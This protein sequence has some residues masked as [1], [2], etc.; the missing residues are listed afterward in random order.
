MKDPRTKNVIPFATGILSAALILASVVNEDTGG[1][2]LAMQTS[3]QAA[4]DKDE[5]V[6]MPVAEFSVSPPD[7]LAE[8]AR[9]IAR[10]KRY[11]N[12]QTE[13]FDEWSP[14]AT[15]WSSISEWYL[16]V[17]A[18]PTA[19]SD[20]VVLGKVIDAKGYL[21]SDKTGAYSEFTVLIDKVF[22]FSDSSLVPGVSI[23]AEREG[24]SVRLPNGR[25]IRYEIAYQGM[26]QVGRQ[27]V[28]FLKYE[29]QGD[30][31]QILTGY[32]VR[33]GFVFPLDDGGHFA[34]YKNSNNET[35]FDGLRE[36][37]VHPPRAPRGKEF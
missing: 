35:F 31:Y 34:I 8:Q 20:A 12:R 14:T 3:K 4:Q 21:S 17:A 5:K 23:I 10:S 37:L 30:D 15:G 7:D 16:Y 25:V 33:K 11:D 26:P 27:Y 28:L 9:R 1:V 2:A 24:A 18:L 19:E 6:K 13:R 32:E 22:K 36:A 29:P